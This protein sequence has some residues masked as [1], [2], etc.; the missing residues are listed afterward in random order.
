MERSNEEATLFVSIAGYRDLELPQTLEDLFAKAKHP[1]RVVAGVLSQLAL[2][3]GYEYRR[4]PEAWKDQIRLVTVDAA[5]S[6]GVCWARH[7]VQNELF[8]LED[9]YLQIDSHSRFDQNWDVLLIDMLARCPTEKAVLTT[10]PLGYKPPDSLTAPGMPVLTASRFDKESILIPKGKVLSLPPEGSMPLPGAFLGAGFVF[11]PGRM[12]REVPYDPFLYFHGEEV[13]MAVRLWTHG[14]DL[15]TPTRPVV[16]HDYTDRGRRR[17]WSDHVDWTGI[18]QRAKA[19]VRHLLAMEPSVDPAILQGLDT[20]YGLGKERS[21]MAY[22]RYADISFVHRYIGTRA[23]DGRFPLRP[24]NPQREKLEKSFEAIHLNNEWKSAETRSGPG[25][26]RNASAG[27]R[28]G[29]IDMLGQLRIRTLLDAGCGDMNWNSDLVHHLD[30][31]LG[32]DLLPD[33]IESNRML[34]GAHK[35]LFFNAADI[36]E[37]QLPAVDAILCRHTLTHLPN[38]LVLKALRN[39]KRSGA[40]HL[41]ATTYPG[42]ENRDIAPGQWRPMDLTAPPFSLPAPRHLLPDGESKNG[43]F[44]GIW[45]LGD[46]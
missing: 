16:Y 32:F 39:V 46:W 10:H 12:V 2:G 30:L 14:Y 22:E 43:C 23:A 24:R 40:R 4:I 34:L 33:L 19:R 45:S 6:M 35:N 36:T 42:K 8:D 25:S 41:L 11:G 44:L 17:H 29:L 27:L 31:F 18:N 20:L 28:A 21:L 26:T 15:F 38:E 7:R 3:D 13:T 37:E 5:S 9:Y 1:R